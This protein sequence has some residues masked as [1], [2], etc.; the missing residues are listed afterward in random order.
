MSGSRVVVTGASRGL[1][2]ALAEAFAAEGADLALTATSEGK[3]AGVL[4]EVPGAAPV[5]LDLRRSESIDA[6]AAAIGDRLGGVDV[7]VNNAGI[8]GARA[9]LAEY[10]MDTWR[11]VMA[12]SVDGALRLTQRLL[13][14]IADGGAIINVTSGA[15]GRPWWGAYGV[16]RLA[17][18]G[19][20]R[21]LRTELAERRI[22]CV[23]INPG[24]V[25][26]E[27]RANAYPDE[28]PLSVPHPRERVEPFL[29]VAAGRDPGWFV[30]AKE[31]EA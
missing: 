10:P 2:R 12:I 21:M 20:T 4:A 18:N 15:A 26:T 29:S 13:P 9:P 8:L 11:E 3:L 23:A 19:I 5:A 30:E 24:G 14:S 31:W 27:M 22:R 16:S 25:R 7:L 28:D 1:G 17:I 6:A